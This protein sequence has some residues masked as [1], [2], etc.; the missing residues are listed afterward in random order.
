MN[1]G[2]ILTQIIIGVVGILITALS[3]YVSY[4]IS[5][6]IKN[7]QVKRIVTSLYDLVKS[8]VLE[9]Q[10]TYVDDLKKSGNF[11]LEAQKQALNRCLEHI[12]VNMPVD[13]ENWLKSNYTDI[14]RYLITLIEAQINLLKK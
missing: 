7:E 8:T 12:R 4:L 13:V 9:I 11:D 6:H 10:Q 1:W 2:E 14:E 5:K 3:G